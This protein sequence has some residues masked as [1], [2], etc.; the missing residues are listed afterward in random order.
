MEVEVE[1]VDDVV[2]GSVVVVE[3]GVVV[4]VDGVVV[5]C[6]NVATAGALASSTI[7]SARISFWAASTPSTLPL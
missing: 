3:A 2:E 5:G 6:W 4:D 1:D 7:V